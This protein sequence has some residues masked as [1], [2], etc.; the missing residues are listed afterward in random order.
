MA[1][2]DTVDERDE[3]RWGN[4]YPFGTEQTTEGSDMQVSLFFEAYKWDGDAYIP[5][6]RFYGQTISTQATILVAD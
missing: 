5:S 1:L 3:F 6:G 2:G 4:G